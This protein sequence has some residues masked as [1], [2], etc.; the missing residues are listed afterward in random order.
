MSH[1]GFYMTC[2]YCGSRLTWNSSCMAADMSDDYEDD[3]TASVNF[4]HCPTC[5]RD[6]EVAEPSEEER[7]GEYADYWI[8]G[9][10]P[11]KNGKT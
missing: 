11:T 5:G 2:M 7:E 4:F 3:D 8:N 10:R 1:D 6:Y 9:K